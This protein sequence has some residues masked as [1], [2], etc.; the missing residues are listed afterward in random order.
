MSSHNAK[1]K[2]G[3]L[4]NMG[5]LAQGALWMYQ[6]VLQRGSV[7]LIT[8]DLNIQMVPVYP[9]WGQPIGNARRM[10]TVNC[11]KN[12]LVTPGEHDPVPE[13][14]LRL[15]LEALDGNQEL[16]ISVQDGILQQYAR[17]GGIPQ[18]WGKG[19]VTSM[20]IETQD[21][22]PTPPFQP[23]VCPVRGLVTKPVS[24]DSFG[25]GHVV[26][27]PRSVRAKDG[28][29][30]LQ[31]PIELPLYFKFV[32]YDVLLMVNLSGTKH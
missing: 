1:A 8:I 20:H 22:R 16:R 12:L 26:P 18:S 4:T 11:L 9:Q 2:L 10:V 27:M 32:G 13:H 17:Q 25:K 7:L 14:R 5:S 15:L 19:A 30:I 6:R 24:L 21:L 31:N 3:T 29:L 28:S 23:F